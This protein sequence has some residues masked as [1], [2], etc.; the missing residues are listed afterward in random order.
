MQETGILKMK[1][2]LFSIGTGGDIEPFPSIVQFHKEMDWE[3]ICV[4]PE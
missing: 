1:A 4:L 3:V 2:T